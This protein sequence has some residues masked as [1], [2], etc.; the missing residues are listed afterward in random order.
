MPTENAIRLPPY[1]HIRRS[2]PHK[3]PY[4]TQPET[5]K[6]YNKIEKFKQNKIKIEKIKQ[7]FNIPQKQNKNP[8]LRILKHT[9]LPQNGYQKIRFY[10][11]YTE[12]TVTNEAENAKMQKMTIFRGFDSHIMRNYYKIKI[13]PY[14]GIS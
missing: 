9:T 14:I 2:D 10:N 11:K 5:K 7:K 1:R 6:L 8:K 12:I 13:L 3:S 4:K